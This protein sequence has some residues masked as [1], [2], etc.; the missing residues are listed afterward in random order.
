MNSG[1]Q[2]SLS[3]P[4]AERDAGT[5][6]RWIAALLFIGSTGVLI[7]AAYLSPSHGLHETIGWP[8]CGFKLTTGLPC[9]TC[10]MT[11]AFTYAAEGDLISA[12]RVQPAGAVLA[13][14]TAIL[15]II[16]GI[17][18]LTSMPLAPLGRAVWR[19]RVIIIGIV[20]L[21]MAWIY[22]TAFTLHTGA[23]PL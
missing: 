14:A 6:S 15:S 3:E 7:V 1:T 11:T 22:T 20:L 13:V 18:M 10:G 21:L 4:T 8:R 23:S 9:V 2:T 16:S 12:I 5:G 19:P 17:A